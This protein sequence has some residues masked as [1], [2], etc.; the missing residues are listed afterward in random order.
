MESSDGK[1][2]YYG[3]DMNCVSLRRISLA[4]GED[5]HVLDIPGEWSLYTLVGPDIYYIA[6]TL[7]R[8]QE[9]PKASIESFRPSSGAR[10]RVATIE[11]PL[12]YGRSEVSPLALNAS[13]D[14]KFLFYTQQDRQVSELMLVDNFR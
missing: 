2:L 4:D 1:L 5:K 8:G 3:K 13:P 6:G 11:K 7:N 9:T 14:G 12:P 10:K